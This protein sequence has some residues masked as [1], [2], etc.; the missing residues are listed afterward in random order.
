VKQKDK[1]ILFTSSFPFGSKETYLETEI[2][3]LAIAFD[4]IEI[5]PHYYNKGNKK[6]R[7]VP[8]NVKVHKA[9]LPN[10]KLKRLLQLLKGILKGAK[11]GLFFKEFFSKKIYKSKVN[12]KSWLLTMIYYI[13]TVGSY[14]YNVIKREE[15]AVFYFYWGFGWSYMILNF[16]QSKSCKSYI[17]LHGSEVYLERSNGYIPLRT[18]LF[19]KTDFLLPISNNLSA[20]LKI[21]FD[22][23]SEKIEVS[24]LGVIVANVLSEK[25]A[26]DSNELNIV[27]CSNIIKLKRIDMI[28]EA[29]KSFDGIPVKWI[30]FGDGPE[31][32][33]IKEQISIKAFKSINIELVGRRSNAEVLDYYNNNRVDVFI[34]VSKYEG[35]PV[36]AMEAMSCKIPCIATNVG[37]TAE[38]INNENGILLEEDFSVDKLVLSIQKVRK[39]D[40]WNKKRQIAFEHCDKYFNADRNYNKLC[41]LLK[42]KNCV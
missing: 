36:S 41:K 38:L 16:N 29:L 12:F 37:A 22:I 21:R 17:R 11:I 28:V 8:K 9:A 23:L 19:Q 15:N 27:S 6:Q 24:R 5:Y 10:K 13:T 34:N 35:I 42:N 31:M 1:L 26:I 3:F 14:Q 33:S 32:N 30:H 39:V 18:K 7:G 25:K 2:E 40:Q 20:Y 4:K